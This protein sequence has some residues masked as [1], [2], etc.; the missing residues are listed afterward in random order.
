MVSAN[1]VR[2]AAVLG[3]S[4]LMGRAIYCFYSKRRNNVKNKNGSDCVQNQ[5]RVES[6]SNRSPERDLKSTDGLL[7]CSSP[8]LSPSTGMEVIL[9]D[10]Y[11][12]LGL[13]HLL[14]PSAISP[15]YL[16]RLL[17]VIMVS[18]N[19]RQALISP[20]HPTQPYL[21]CAARTPSR[22]VTPPCAHTW[23]GQL[24]PAEGHLQ[25]RGGVE[26][27]LLHGHRHEDEARHRT[28]PA[29]AG[30]LR[31]RPPRVRPPLR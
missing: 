26:Q 30:R 7:K 27:Q 1:F 9:N 22:K 18:S 6:N 25:R 20:P 2:T 5:I 17:P 14:L 31:A 12:T 19:K 29:A 15:Q 24:P 28:R 13:R 21:V 3:I 23:P 4:V 11:L 16:E 10:E 8:D